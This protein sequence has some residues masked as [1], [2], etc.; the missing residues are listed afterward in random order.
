MP[1]RRLTSLLVCLALAALVAVALGNHSFAAARKAC[2]VPSVKGKSLG[3]AKSALRRK[4]CGLGTVQRSF[5]TTVPRQHV[6]SQHPHAGAH[7]PAGAKVSLLVSKGKRP[8][9]LP[10]VGTVVASLQVP[11]PMGVFSVPGA[12]WVSEHDGDSIDRID[13]S[14]NK[15]VAHVPVAKDGGQ[16]A[17]M[18]LGGDTML[19]SNYSS[20]KLALVDPATNAIKKIVDG[21]FENCCDPTYGGGSFWLLE[22]SPGADVA[23]HLI[24]LDPSGT[25]QANLHVPVAGGVT[26][27][28]GSVWGSSKGKVFRLDPATNKITARIAKNVPFPTYGAGSVWGVTESGND[29][30]RIDPASNAVSASIH[31]P[32]PGDVVVATDGAVWVADAADN[33]QG[34]RLWKI[35]PAT[36]KVVGQVK[37]GH[38]DFINL[39][40]GSDGSVWVALFYSDLVL[41]VHPS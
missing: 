39:S 28:D 20:Q 33:G 16:P 9:V 31:L 15:V 1:R 21:P 36:N 35:D 10:S 12:V 6:I 38:E 22:V 26:F 3:A 23:D 13:P 32:R 27:G 41:R 40:V 2:V 7:R 5:S 4:G 17:R 25:V 8:A 37:L 18:A 29:L 11:S 34:S 30:I 24:R 19:A 14:S